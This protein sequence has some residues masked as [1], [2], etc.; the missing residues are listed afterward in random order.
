[1]ENVIKS[2]KISDVN[3][4]VANAPAQQYPSYMRL[5]YMSRFIVLAY[6]PCDYLLR[7]YDVRNNSDITYL[8]SHLLI[9]LP[10]DI[11]SSQ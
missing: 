6:P 4:F 8:P 2:N 1:M 11:A 10:S 9:G 5:P 3:T 7:Q